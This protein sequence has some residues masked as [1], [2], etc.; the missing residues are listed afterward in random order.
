MPPEV[1]A[2]VTPR[3]QADRPVGEWNFQEVTVKG[4]TIVTELNGVVILN[5][6]LSKIT[7]FM[8]NT[9]S[10]FVGIA[11]S[12]LIERVEGSPGMDELRHL[13][14]DW[15]AAIAL[16]G[17]GRKRLAEFEEKLAALLS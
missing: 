8:A 3:T 9:L 16:T 17:D 13:F 10:A 14:G 2:A 6:D 7:N 5:T 11:A 1:R 15:R 12:S 4:S